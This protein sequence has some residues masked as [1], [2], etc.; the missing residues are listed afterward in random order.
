[1]DR[2]D[3][4]QGRG[5]GLLVYVKNGLTVLKVDTE[6][7]FHQYC[8]FLVSDITFYLIYRSPNA[9]PEAMC[10]LERVVRNVKKNSIL[11][12]YFNLPSIDWETGTGP[13]RTSSFIEV[14]DDAMMTQMVDFSTQ[15]KENCLDL[16]L[17]YL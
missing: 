9:P 5:G 4:M 13:G 7:K 15:V 12:G 17:T 3:T 11:V 8:M 10:A 6:L 16:V 14:V 2:E 1:M